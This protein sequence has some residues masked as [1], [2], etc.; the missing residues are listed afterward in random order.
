VHI[1]FFAAPVPATGAGEL[2]ATG[3]TSDGT[4]T[5]LLA[6]AIGAWRE[7][8]EPA[9]DHE[10]QETALDEAVSEGVPAVATTAEEAEPTAPIEPS[11]GDERPA[12]LVG[13]APVHP[14]ADAAAAPASVLAP[15]PISGAVPG[16]TADPSTPAP[17]GEA[18]GP[19]GQAPLDAGSADP[20]S[21]DPLSVDVVTVPPIPAESADGSLP[22]SMAVEPEPATVPPTD[23][24][25]EPEITLAAVVAA[26]TPGAGGSVPGAPVESL[27]DS[28]AATR[29]GVDAAA[30]PPSVPLDAAPSPRVEAPS[31]LAQALVDAELEALEADDP[32]QQLATVVRPLRQLADG[33][34]R[35]ALQLRPAELGAVHLEVALEDGHL[36]MRLV[37]ETVAARDAL[38]ASM[39][40]LRGELTRSGIDVGSLDVGDQTMQGDTGPT[41]PGATTDR[42]TEPRQPEPL[43]AASTTPSPHPGAPGGRVDLSL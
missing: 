34:H 2:I 33:T 27:V 17:A 42:P 22:E 43:I 21:A 7:D 41:V 11:E 31:T 3:G 8:A 5:E 35:I 9:D 20:L 24:R 32:W 15:G 26:A 39:P 38:A 19:A 1:T 16:A 28:R 12:E 25:N 14:T 10:N 30:A 29:L 18:S 36:S 23:G 37:A 6:D 40:D 13:E 4:F